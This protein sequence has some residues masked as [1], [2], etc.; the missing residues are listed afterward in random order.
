MR[1]VK[2]QAPAGKG[3]EVA[4]LAFAVGIAQVTV[5]QEQVYRSNQARETKDVVD[6]EAATPLAKAFIDAILAASFFD[7]TVYAI[8]VRQPRSIISREGPA[9]LTKPFVVPAIDLMEELWQFSHVTFGFVGRVALA[10][11]LLAYGMI[12]DKLLIIIAGLLFM[13]LLPLL[14]AISFGVWRREWHLAWQGG[15]AFVIAIVL[16]IVAGALVAGITGP[17]LR[18]NEANSLI[19]SLLIS[20]AV[21]IAAG[22]ATAD[23]VG[24][25]ELIGLAAV[26]QIAIL[27]TWF[28]IRLV[29]GSAADGSMSPTARALTLLVNVSMIVIAAL[30]TYAVLGLRGSGMARSSEDT[31]STGV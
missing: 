30:G 13:P 7:P 12:A 16:L 10:A 24:R 6:I 20:L 21:G 28:G 27:P 2:V 31:P 19:T 25:R 23:D 14:L 18:F 4:Q 9:T 15:R 22:L 26:A 29:F 8:T 5:R 11:A 3:E 17:P 1:L